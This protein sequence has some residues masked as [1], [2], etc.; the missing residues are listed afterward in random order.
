[1]RTDTRPCLAKSPILN[2]TRPGVRP[3]TVSGSRCRLVRPVAS[4]MGGEQGPDAPDRLDRV[5]L[6]RRLYRHDRDEVVVMQLQAG[7]GRTPA[8]L[9]RAHH[10]PGQVIA[11]DQV[12]DPDAPLVRLD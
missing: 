12:A 11:A 9:D 10:V 3:D 5:R 8:E 1:M 4:L 7:P 6:V 2:M